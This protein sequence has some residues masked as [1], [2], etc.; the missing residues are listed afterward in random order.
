[1]V[2]ELQHNVPG[3]ATASV[4]RLSTGREVVWLEVDGEHHK[5]ALSA[6]A[7]HVIA[8]A[9]HTARTKGLPLVLQIESSG[10]DIMEGIPALHGWGTAAKALAEGSGHIPTSRSHIGD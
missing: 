7:S 10:A 2:L 5:G 3:A 9:A 4:S 8:T 6:A 1:M